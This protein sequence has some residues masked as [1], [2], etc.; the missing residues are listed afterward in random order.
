MLYNIWD[1]SL[2][3]DNQDPDTKNENVEDPIYKQ[4]W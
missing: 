4:T 1:R 3:L 2:E